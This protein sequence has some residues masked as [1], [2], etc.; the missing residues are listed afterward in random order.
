MRETVALWAPD[1]EPPDDWL[2]PAI[3]YQDKI[4]TFAPEPYLDDRDGR[5]SRRIKNL[6]GDLYE[7]VSLP[8]TFANGDYIEHEL[9]ARVSSWITTARRID[10]KRDSYIGRWADRAE[11]FDRRRR[12][13]LGQLTEVGNMIR[14]AQSH[15]ARVAEAL[16]QLQA[17]MRL[18]ED[19]LESMKAVARPSIKAAKLARQEEIDPLVK[20]VRMLWQQ[21]RDLNRASQD[22]RDVCRTLDELRAQI[23]ATRRSDDHPG[24]SE[25]RDLEE[26]IRGIV[27]EVNDA[28]TELNTL[29]GTTERLRR[30]RERQQR[31]I[32]CPW[33]SDQE[34]SA[35]HLW[36]LPPELDTI[37]VGKIYG[38]VFHF[39]AS[40]AGMWVAGRRDRPYAGTLVGPKFVVDDIM[41]TV[42][43]HVAADRDDC[44]LMLSEQRRRAL[45]APTD[46]LAAAAAV[47]WLLPVPQTSDLSAVRFFRDQHGDE[48][49]S[50]RRYIQTPLSSAV[51]FEDLQDAIRDIQISCQSAAREISRALELNRRVGLAYI[52]G[53]VVS[54]VGASVRDTAVAAG[55]GAIPAL[56]AAMDVGDPLA[57]APAG[58]MVTGA[59]LTAM[60]AI[61]SFR[62]W[63]ARRR[64]PSP[65]L[66]TYEAL[67]ASERWRA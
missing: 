15:E 2:V 59:T 24:A 58:L 65:F 10:P 40:S 4:A 60:T 56:H 61:N 30:R 9:R 7:P 64:V 46:A 62:A 5:A 16:K 43:T 34:F 26:Q 12:D 25:I 27:S 44:A 53:S 22:Y 50:L 18:R 29:R 19:R 33:E 52:R 47:T 66:Y 37:A 6:L 38:R 49:E 13:V 14:E 42:A 41:L 31:W 36:N 55:L 21:R 51:T 28:A 32:D 45:S 20:Q 11:G 54:E 1:I 39:L 48:L 8:A 23:D 35:G 17:D 63:S 57:G 3:L 67:R